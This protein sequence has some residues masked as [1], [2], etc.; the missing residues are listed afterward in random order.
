[1]A[2]VKPLHY[3]INI[4]LGYGVWRYKVLCVQFLYGNPPKSYKLAKIKKLVSCKRCLKLLY[5]KV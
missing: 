3:K 4:G 1:M 5:G 2:K